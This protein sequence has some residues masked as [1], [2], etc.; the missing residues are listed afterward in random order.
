MQSTATTGRSWLPR[1]AVSGA[2]FWLARREALW[3]K[4][5]L[6]RGFMRLYG[7]SLAE[8][9]RGAAE[10]YQHFNDFFTR[11]LQATARPIDAAADTFVSP[12]DGTVA[13]MGSIQ[14]T[15]LLQAKGLP[16]SAADLLADAALAERFDGGDFVT[17][18]LSPSDY[19][20]VHTPAS[21]RFVQQRREGLDRFS[22]NERS[23]RSVAGLYVRNERLVLE[24]DVAGRPLA[25]VLV[26]ALN[27]GSI[28]S[29]WD[30]AAAA[31]PPDRVGKGDEVGRFNLGSTVVVLTP[32]GMVRWDDHLAPGSSV[33]MGQ[34]VGVCQPTNDADSTPTTP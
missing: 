3:L 19:H 9:Q 33:K 12:C 13:E 6:I 16:Y 4:N 11:S 30:S 14:D 8:A 23:T 5:A 20:R 17:I 7:I 18:Y 22:V 15:T 24:F 32:A 1:R 31:D 10:D 25:I 28:S 26:G 34:R 2:M 27:V 29:P 21:A